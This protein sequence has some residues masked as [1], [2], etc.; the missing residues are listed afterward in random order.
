MTEITNMEFINIRI[1]FNNQYKDCIK[2]NIFQYIG[3]LSTSFH[4]ELT[5]FCYNC[6]DVVFTTNETN[7]KSIVHRKMMTIYRQK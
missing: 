7:D 4:D 3:K 6:L 1:T 2:K 5:K